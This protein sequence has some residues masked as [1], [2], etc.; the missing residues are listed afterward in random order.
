MTR[1]KGWKGKG[2]VHLVEK[3]KKLVGVYWGHK[4]FKAVTVGSCNC[5]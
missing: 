4:L 2:A 5:S 3:G 1:E